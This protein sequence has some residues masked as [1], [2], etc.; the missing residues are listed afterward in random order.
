MGSVCACAPARDAPFLPL[1]GARAGFGC[2][3]DADRA[4][5]VPVLPPDHRLRRSADFR[6]ALRQGGRT[7]SRT[8]VVHAAVAPH[9][10]RVGFAVNRAVGG[11]VVRNKVKRRLRE[12]VRPQLEPLMQRGSWDIVVRA[13]PQAAAASFDELSADVAAAVSGL[14]PV[15]A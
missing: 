3:P 11:S 9:G 5:R 12:A 8:V 2:L 6:R 15:S 7:T 13:T 14:G 4:V 1:A 10:V